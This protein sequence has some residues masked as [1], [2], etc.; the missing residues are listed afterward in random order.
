M[1][2]VPPGAASDTKKYCSKI[3]C[4]P[5]AGRI[6]I[7]FLKEFCKSGLDEPVQ[8]LTHRG[9]G[10]SYPNI[11]FA[12]NENEKQCKEQSAFR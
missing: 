3:Q 8:I 12:S 1:Y 11:F 5:R 6:C 4:I 7:Q 2:R 9:E 10:K